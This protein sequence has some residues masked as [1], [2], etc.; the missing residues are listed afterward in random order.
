MDR[1]VLTWSRLIE[2]S[3]LLNILTPTSLPEV[4]GVYR[5]SYKS[6]DG[7]I[8]V[9]YVG[10]AENIKDR[11]R[12]HFSRGEENLCIKDKLTKFTCYIRYARID[13]S[14]VRNGAEKFLYNHYN[15][16]C[17]L[18]TPMGSDILIN[19]ENER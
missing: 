8:Y 9:F 7:N 1:Y 4:A 2:I 19:I 3:P 12:F 15:P 11:V 16:T 14:N 18:I 13:N 17:N 5:L 6:S 10:Q